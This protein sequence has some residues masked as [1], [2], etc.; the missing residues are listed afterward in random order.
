MIKVSAQAFATTSWKKSEINMRP[1]DLYDNL[2]AGSEAVNQRCS[3]KKV[4]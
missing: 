1:S 4:S 2:H 3:V